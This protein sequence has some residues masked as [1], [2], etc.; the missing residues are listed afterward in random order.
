MLII[1]ALA[2]LMLRINSAIT[3]MIKINIYNKDL[4]IKLKLTCLNSFI[5][6]PVSVFK[7]WL[8]W[9]ISSFWCRPVSVLLWESASAQLSD[10]AA[11]TGLTRVLGTTGT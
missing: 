11:G 7:V 2:A 4:N 9:L 3:A 8:V 10:H 6:D 1:L 5:F